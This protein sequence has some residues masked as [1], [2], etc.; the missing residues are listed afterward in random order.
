MSDAKNDILDF[1]EKEILEAVVKITGSKVGYHSGVTLTGTLSR[2]QFSGIR[3]EYKGEV[4]DGSLHG[5]GK[6][7]WSNGH[8]YE[9][10]W[11]KNKRHGKG[12]YTWPDTTCY[13][14]EYENGKCH[15]K[16]K[17]VYRNGDFFEGYWEN[18]MRHGEGKYTYASSGK[19]RVGRWDNDKYV[20]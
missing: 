4:E 20:N 17:L 1:M 2:G 10:G 13:E 12:K 7:I 11:L 5:Q 3:W 18:G 8:E 9:G 16:G 6:I 14:G 15:G 19:E